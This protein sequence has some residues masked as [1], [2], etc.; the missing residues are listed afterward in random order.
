MKAKS[1]CDDCRRSLISLDSSLTHNQL[2]SLDRI[3]ELAGKKL[4]EQKS[5]KN[6]LYSLVHQAKD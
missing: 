2:L 3:F 6:H 5:K 4:E 1:L